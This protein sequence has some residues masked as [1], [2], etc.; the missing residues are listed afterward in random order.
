MARDTLIRTRKTLEKSAYVAVGI[1][2]SLIGMLKDRWEG[3]RETI[4]DMRDRLSD[5]AR[6]AFDEWVQEGEK[7][8]DGLGSQ[9]REGK[10]RLERGLEERTGTVRTIGRGVASSLSHPVLPVSE[11]EG[12]GPAYADR[13]AKAGIFSIRALLDQSRNE[14]TRLRLSEQTGIGMGQLEGWV[15]K[16]DLTAIDGIGDEYLSLLHAIGIGSFQSLASADSA[17]MRKQ[18][19]ALNEERALVETIPGEETFSRWVQAAGGYIR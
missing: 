10:E 3:T 13:L 1:P 6:Q 16:T 18:A 2:A 7:L 4:D 14:E 8:L 12:V 17:E 11:I 5:D 9:L 19:V 15:A